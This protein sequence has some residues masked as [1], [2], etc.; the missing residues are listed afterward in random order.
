MIHLPMV[1]I[2]NAL[3]TYNRAKVLPKTL[4]S[5]LAQAYGDFELIISDDCSSD[6]TE[7]VYREYVRKDPDREILSERREPQEARQPQCR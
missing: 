1:H 7:E 3:T 6:Q 5:L 4:D 2:S